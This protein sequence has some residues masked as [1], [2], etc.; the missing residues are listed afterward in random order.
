MKSVVLAIIIVAAV[1]PTISAMS[2]L[3]VAAPFRVAIIGGGVSGCASARRL[4]QLA[5]TAQITLYE[6]GRGPGGRA[7]TRKTRS[8]PGVCINHGAPYCD[9]RT[10]L[11]KSLLS[12][13]DTGTAPFTGV[14]GCLEESTGKFSPYKKEEEDATTMYIT[15]ANGEM[16]QISSSLL[17][18]LPSKSINTK[19]KTMIR[20][21]AKTADGVW[22]MRDKADTLIGSADWL[23]VAGS[24][25]AHPRWTK[26]FG[27]VPPLIEAESNS[28]DPLLRQALDEIAKQQTSPVMTVFFS[29][30]GQVAR[31]WLSLD[32]N[33]AEV[34]GSSSILSKI[35]VHGNN[36]GDGNNEIDDW[37]SVV[38]HSTE[39]FANQNS[40]T[41][42]ASS[43]AARIAGAASDSSLEDA[44]IEKM[45][46]A[47]AEIPGI[48]T[49]IDKVKMDDNSYYG[50][51]LHRWGN[52]FPKGEALAQDLA[53]LP[54]SRISF[55][56]D[57]VAS[58]EQARLGSCEAALLSGTFAGES[59][60]NYYA[61]S[62]SN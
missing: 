38:L 16:S 19:Y 43:S 26:S 15:G 21:L 61:E 36:N 8:L 41:Y 12:S 54:S 48:P 58:P 5:P 2:V 52:A 34:E 40:G 57:Y 49:I 53:F 32:F 60:A 42:G 50:P 6:I 11:G 1:I 39:D 37:C 10:D 25:V 24:G 18:D 59:I 23:I 17:S 47:L 31:E 35:I 29:F 62:I 56:G 3:T 7:S 55:C 9:I 44:L 33:V 27:G 51:M 46:N 28:P 20:G 45:M 22:E 4:A 30:T 14:R 13:L